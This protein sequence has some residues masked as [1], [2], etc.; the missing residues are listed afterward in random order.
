MNIIYAIST[1]TLGYFIVAQS[2]QG[3]CFL[4]LADEPDELMT[5]LHQRFGQKNISNRA[6]IDSETVQKI[7][8][9]LNAPNATLDLPLDLYGTAF[10]LKV[11]EEIRLIPHGKTTSYTDIAR[12][13]GQPTAARAVAQ[14]CGA[15]KLAIIVPC[16]RV[17][18]SNGAVSGYRWGIERKKQL[19]HREGIHIF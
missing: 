3:I 2:K 12:R 19:L 7:K 1:C 5:E 9:Y 4:M 14:A 6:Q 18:R 16:H 10:Q 11:W 17:V 15:N 13:I 8:A